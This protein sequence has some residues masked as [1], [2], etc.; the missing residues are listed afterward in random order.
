MAFITI[1][2]DGSANRIG[3]DQAAVFYC[4]YNELVPAVS[5]T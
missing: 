4:G 5:N 1:Y 3:S 2:F